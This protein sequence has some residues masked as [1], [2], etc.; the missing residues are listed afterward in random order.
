MSELFTDNTDS[1]FNDTETT[2]VVVT[3]VEPM[4]SG[5]PDTV[6]NTATLDEI[7]ESPSP[8]SDDNPV[9]GSEAG[10]GQPEQQTDQQT[11]TY[12][13][14][15]IEALLTQWQTAQEEYETKTLENQEFFIEQSK[16]QLT[17]SYLSILV[18]GFLSGILLARIVW[19]KL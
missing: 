5:D 14:D 6:E 11:K 4:P 18:I 1:S 8:A 13:M 2:E 15:D 19:R 17:L 12:S 9:T 10:D 16:N 7:K 3:P